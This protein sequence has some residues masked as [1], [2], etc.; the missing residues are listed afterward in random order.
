VLLSAAFAQQ[1]V[2]PIEPLER[3][4]WAAPFRLTEVVPWSAHAELRQVQEGW[5]VEVR[6]P[7]ESLRQRQVA[8]PVL[9]V[10]DLP[11]QRFGPPGD[12][13]CA[14]VVVPG[15]IDLQSAR[16]YFGSDQLPERVTRAHG[17]LELEA[18]AAAGI[19]PLAPLVVGA[20]LELPGDRALENIARER[21][22]ACAA[23]L[24]PATF[25]G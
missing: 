2:E 14:I 17:A 5:I 22:A 8:S 11:V 16:W 10:E 15:P 9:Y 23:E 24:D 25:G 21:F 13:G 20:L 6:S 7:K 3:V 1:P 18:A 12:V 19:K 4:V